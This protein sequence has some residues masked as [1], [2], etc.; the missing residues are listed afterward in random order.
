MKFMETV[1]I[2]FAA[3]TNG[4]TFR[5][6]PREWKKWTRETKKEIANLVTL[7]QSSAREE[8]KA[9]AIIVMFAP[10]LNLLPRRSFAWKDNTYTYVYDGNHLNFSKLSVPLQQF[11][12]KV[13]CAGIEHSQQYK[14]K[15]TTY[16]RSTSTL[17]YYSEF[18][19]QLLTVMDPADPIAKELFDHYDLNDWK[20]FSC[21]FDDEPS[22]Y[23][24]FDRLLRSNASPEW[25]TLADQWMRKRIVEEISGVAHPRVAYECALACYIRH[26]EKCIGSSAY[27]RALFISQISFIVSEETAAY[28]GILF[29]Y[30]KLSNLLWFL[31]KSETE[32]RA[33]VLY[34]MA[35]ALPANYWIGTSGF[36][37]YSHKK[38]AITLLLNECG[39]IDELLREKLQLILDRSDNEEN[40]LQQKKQNLQDAENRNLLALS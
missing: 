4:K 19:L 25:K 22:G 11:A 5:D 37:E 38:S 20:A 36:S 8:F 21:P 13:M 3:L 16:L 7:I 10:D 15:K 30:E 6:I 40:K 33:K 18:C 27:E 26:I 34:R 2:A 35:K 17:G 32:L 9:M 39:P 24:P 29:Q 14:G 12:A 31:G 28:K 23:N 1:A